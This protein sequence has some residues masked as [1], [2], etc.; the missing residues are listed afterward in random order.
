VYPASI[1]HNGRVNV[2]EAL[3]ARYS[4]RGYRA[5]PVPEELI[6]EVFDIA[7]LAA[8]GTNTQPWHVAVVSGEARYRLQNQ[9]CDLFDAGVA[10][11]RG[12]PGDADMDGV[13]LD[14]RR[15]CGFG[16][17]ETMGVERKD[18]EGRMRIARKNFEFFGAPHVA[19]FS[20]P[21]TFTFPQAVDMGIFLQ[22]VMLVMVEKGLGCIA[23]GSLAG[24]PSPVREIADMP[25]E[26]EIMF[27]LSFGYE[28][29]AAHINTVRM[30]RA[31]VDDFASFTS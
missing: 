26:N 13:Y 8:S 25:D 3:Q 24:Y 29:P 11:Q 21:R 16:Y 22:A 6:R 5:D 28:D 10:Q 20:M 23:Q 1:H 19:F 27:G 18:R 7:R 4:V 14:R 9:L 17:Y 15:A 12:F 31:S 30:T 2:A